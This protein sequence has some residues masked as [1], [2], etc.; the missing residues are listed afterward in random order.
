M[1]N[2]QLTSIIANMDNPSVEKYFNEIG[3]EKLITAQEEV[4]L[5][6]KIRQ[7]DRTARER[8][9]RSNL[10]FVV[11]VAKKYQYQG[12]P[13]SDLISE[14]NLG[15]I[16]AAE[17]FD[18]FKFFSFAVWWIRQTISSAITEHARMIRLPMNKIHDIT[19]INKAMAEIEQ[20]TLRHLTIEPTGKISRRS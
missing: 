10:R 19:R 17:R 13:L 9:I 14:G 6:A 16:K 8:L 18:G 15:L 11:S 3:R 1:R 20:G 4:S 12:L 7:G 2:I 5:A